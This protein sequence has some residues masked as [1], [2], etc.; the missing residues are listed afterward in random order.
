MAKIRTLVSTRAY[1]APGS[2]S[3]RLFE[4]A[5]QALPGGNSRTTIF[6]QPYPIYAAEGSGCWLTD[7]D[8]DQRFDCLNNYTSLIHGHAHPAV[9]DAVIERVKRGTAF[10]LPTPEEVELAALLVDRLPSVDRVRFANSG[11]EAVMT[12]IKAARAFTGRAAIAK[13]EGAYHGSYDWAEVSL[14]PAS[15]EWGPAEEPA[16]IA[17]TK[18]T[19]ASVLAD[20]VVL[21]FNQPEL[22]ARRVEREAER[23]AAVIVD[24]LPNRVGLIPATREFLR[25]LR[26][27]TAAH[28]ILL[29]FDEVISFRLSYRGAQG[30]FGIRP[31]LTTLAK[32]IG[33]GF[34]VGAVGGRSDVMAVFDP[35][36]GK[37]AVPHA[38]TFN[39]NPVTM[40]AGLATMQLLDEAAH[41][42]LNALAAELRKG[43]EARFHR[44]GFPGSVTGL[45]SLF[46]IHPHQRELTDY[47][48]SVLSSDETRRLDALYRGLLDHGV[49]I[50]PSGLGCLSTVMTEAEVDYFLEALDVAIDLA[51]A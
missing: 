49:V 36:P 42:R 15:G 4:A 9:N 1:S 24:P 35:R 2:R 44:A 30:H 43:I 38:G 26:D 16:S 25:T 6:M 19:P 29:I 23:L 48:S 8:G 40:A 39:A 34:P 5:V 27:V 50:A 14:G 21:P 37:P 32:I 22:A 18:G 31:D 11:S 41:V 10:S 12:A 47:R 13:C 17:Y 20:V 46:R 51:R 3:A 7:V 28:G 45:G 33:G